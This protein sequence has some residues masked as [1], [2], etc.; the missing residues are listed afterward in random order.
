[1]PWRHCNWFLATA[2]FSICTFAVNTGPHEFAPEV[3]TLMSFPVEPIE[4]VSMAVRLTTAP[5]GSES[6]SHLVFDAIKALR[7]LR[8]REAAGSYVRSIRVKVFRNY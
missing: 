6:Q 4:S 7:E 1:M 2:S 8:D 5:Q 3:L